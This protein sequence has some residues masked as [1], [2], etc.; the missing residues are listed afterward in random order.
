M[1]RVMILRRK[2]EFKFKFVR[3]WPL[4]AGAFQGQWNSWIEPSRLRMG[5]RPV[6]YVQ[7]QPRSWTRDYIEQIQ[8]VVRA[9]LELGIS[10]FLV[11]RPNHS[12]SLV[13][14]DLMN[15]IV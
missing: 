1:R 2:F 12:A 13:L 15:T 9:G 8:L 6:G 10:R 3:N 5:G 4:P 11:R 14:C 7:G